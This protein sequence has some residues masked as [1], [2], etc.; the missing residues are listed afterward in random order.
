MTTLKTVT[1]YLRAAKSEA[2]EAGESTEGMASSVSKLREDILSLTNQKVDLMIDSSTFKSTYQILKELSEVWD[3]LTDTTRANIL[4]MIGGKRN[5]NTVSALL[6]NFQDAED[7]LETAA[8]SAGS[9]LNENEKYLDSINGKLAQFSAAFEKLSDSFISSDLIKTAVDGGTTILN[10]LDDITTT[11]GSFP[12][13]LTTIGGLIT[14]YLSA[15]GNKNFGVLGGLFDIVDGHVAFTGGNT[16]AA[17]ARKYITE[18]NEALNSS[19]GVQQTFID[20]LN[21]TDKT[22]SEYIGTLNGSKASISGYKTYCK[23]AGAS[24]EAFGASAKVASL[25]V[26]ALNI[27]TNALIS[28][29]VGLFIQ[30][31]ASEISSWIT[32]TDDAI[33]K[34]NELTKAFDDFRQ[35]N[36]D[37]ITKLEGLRDEFEELSVGVSRYGENVSLSSDEY[38]RY[39]QI[40]QEIVEISPSL[41]EGYSLENGYLADKNE[42]IERA[43]EL[44]EQEYKNELSQITTTEKLSEII[45][46]YAA[47][48]NKLQNGDILTT[49]TDL[50][51][52]IWQMFRVNERDVVPEFVGVGDPADNKYRYLSEQ[53][54]KALGVTDIGEELNKY[55]NE[56][57]YYQ[58]GSF[59][60]D[61][62]DQV[63]NSIGKIAASIDYAEAGFESLS[64]FETA[65]EKTKNAA[66]NYTEARDSLEKANQDVANELKLVAQNNEAYDGLSEEAQNIVSNFVDRFGVED[67]TR[68]NI[69]GSLVPDADAI[70]D[71]KVQINDFIEKLTPEVQDAVSGM[72]DL[73]SLFDTGDISVNEYRGTID[74]ITQDLKAAG[75]DDDTVKYLELSLDIDKI[76]AQI[77]AVRDALTDADSDVEK[78]ISGM[79]KQDLEYAYEIIARDGSMSFDELLNK[80][81]QLKYS[82]ADMVNVFDFTDM[83]SGLDDAKEGLDNI[84][85]AMDKLNSGTALTKQQLASLALEYPKLLEQANL[86]TDGSITGQQN[87]LNTILELKEKEYDAEIEKK[88][89]ELKATEEVINAQ[90]E[91][92]TAKA[93][94]ISELETATVNGQVDNQV[95]LVNRMTELNDLQGQNYVA[96]EDGVLKVN[97]EALNAKTEAEIEYGEKA[98]TNIWEPYANTIKTASTQGYSASLKATNEYGS[99]LS[100]KLKNIA[101]KVWKGLSSAVS[102]ALKGEWKGISY[103][104]SSGLSN[105]DTNVDGGDITVTFDGATAYVGEQRIDEWVS[106]QREAS[107]ARIE[108][109]NDFKTRTINAYKNL[110][111]L[112]GLNITEIYGLEGS[113]SGSSSSSSDKIEE[114]IADI[115][116]YYE[117]EKKLEAATERA[118]SISKKLQHSDDLTE[119]IQLSSDLV[120]AYKEQIDAEQELMDLKRNTIEANADALRSLGFDVD[121][122][123]S[124]NELLINNLEHLNEL[125]AS[126]AGEYDT[127]QEAT[128]ALR[129]E[130]EELINTTEDL[131]DDNIEAASNIED[132]GYTI[133]ETKND[134]ID[135]IEDVYDKQT[136]AYQKIIDLR[137]EMIESAKDE[138]DY[139]SDIADKVQEIAELQAKIDQLALDDSRS[140]KAERASLIEEL[141]E[142]QKDLADTQSDHSTEAQTDA[143]DKLSD[144]YTNNKEAELELLKNTVGTSEELWTAFYKTLLG[145][146]AS[147]GNSINEEIANAWINAANAVREYGES[148][149]GLST[150]GTVVSNIPKF[151]SGGVVDEA[152]LGK[153]EA[154]AVLQKGE[155][156]LNDDKQ[157]S[158]YKIIDFQAELS[159]RLGVAVGSFQMG[160]APSVSIGETLN[161]LTHDIASVG[162]Q[163]TVY[164][165]HFEVN[166]AHNGN[167]SDSD[168]RAYGEQIAGVAIDK[169]YSAFERRGINS[170]KSSRLKP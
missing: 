69:W 28:L 91:M 142:K 109:L 108:A 148:V 85:S 158:L 115:D 35:S 150:V 112:K 12:T 61:Y 98:A 74:L 37:S 72:I 152:N 163:N 10:L 54:M 31:V 3:E 110:E 60:D 43:I 132:L 165:P 147:V 49:D 97:E 166:I 122:N 45:K 1:M 55:T 162:A 129:K 67:V 44:Q 128:N 68:T 18:Y 21:G 22:L 106:K 70:T 170:T 153:E 135:Y 46:G 78:Y 134:I 42:L 123:A 51:S 102:D 80:I 86:F 121:Y 92:E 38:E 58:W 117:A 65:V 113:L 120:D 29:G 104:F 23:Q 130:T 66:V 50:S 124:T 71:V 63:S 53:I 155:V 89:K 13:L 151:H 77:E 57:G 17:T 41:Q 20:N 64:D 95:E 107:T 11:L 62:S 40:V 154:L 5:S 83:V 9:A 48:Y 141:E 16:A 119:Q 159:K 82:S 27:A 15:T 143:L 36:S 144:D 145:Q 90:L 87:F 101:S 127:L 137:K 7:V 6:T 75:F 99:K 79:S 81:E 100:D 111:A 33:E 133:Q 19:T 125:T 26:K 160:L 114:Y 8:N 136:D 73:K 94:I 168:A 138:L 126:S 30:A 164:E 105:N 118:E 139:E 25:G 2:E 149:N 167:M 24:T 169:L 156:V 93:N 116:E 34:T 52:S 84:I 32:A 103:Y 56:Q 14:T 4:E 59:W 76:D 140:A 146:S 88:I 39:R 131:N 161:S 47:S 157:N 96:L